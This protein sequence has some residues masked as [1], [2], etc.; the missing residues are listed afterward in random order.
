[1][2]IRLRASVSLLGL[3]L[4]A[5]GL[6]SAE[7]ENLKRAR[8]TYKRTVASANAR[9]LRTLDYQI[10]KLST[11]GDEKSLQRAR[12]AKV[13]FEKTG[14]LSQSGDIVF[15]RANLVRDKAIDRAKSLLAD[16]Y[17]KAI[18]RLGDN[19]EKSRTILVQQYESTIRDPM[20]ATASGEKKIIKPEEKTALTVYVPVN[21]RRITSG[22]MDDKSRRFGRTVFVGKNSTF[23]GYAAFIYCETGSKVTSRHS[24]TI[25]LKKGASYEGDAR[26]I[27]HEH[28]ATI[29]GA[30]TAKL[31]RVDK[32]VFTQQKPF[33]LTGLTLGEDGRPVAGARVVANSLHSVSNGDELASFETTSDRKGRYSLRI[34]YAVAS[35]AVYFDGKYQPPRVDRHNPYYRG[36][37]GPWHDTSRV[38]FNLPPLVRLSGVVKDANNRP[39]AN[40][41]VVAYEDQK[42]IAFVRTDSRGQYRII[43][44]KLITRI[45]ANVDGEKLT[46]KISG[47]QDFKHDFISK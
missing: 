12:E 5:A 47:P 39:L 35:L 29:V 7:E 11:K 24:G 23:R 20:A 42:E 36:K 16:V 37:V 15:R 18:K 21:S 41:L 32:I 9:F 1:M 27:Y 2:R 46:H 38:D 25:Y 6:P 44:Q 22:K 40:I 3:C 13:A 43:S 33:I 19:Q 45:T 14:I 30:R 34:A 31:Q 17:N 28:G 8:Q 4:L 26:V 10:Q